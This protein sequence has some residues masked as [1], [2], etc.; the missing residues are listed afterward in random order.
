MNIRDTA[1]TKLQTLPEPLLQEINDFIDFIVHR[2]QPIT[3][4]SQPNPISHR[5]G[6]NG[7]K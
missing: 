2:H 6:P 5:F 4:N 3:V 1:I 7:L